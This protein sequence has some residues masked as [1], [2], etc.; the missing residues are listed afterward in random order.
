MSVVWHDLECGRYDADLPLW[1]ELASQF[2]APILDV[3]AGTGRV[4]LP[5][6]Q[7][8]HSVTALDNE[9]ELLAELAW[10]ADGL[11]L[12]TVNADAREFELARK[13]GLCVVPMQTVQLLG[14]SDGRLAFLDRARRH[15]LGGGRLAVAVADELDVFELR[16]GGLG[17]LPD[18]TELEG[19]VYSSSPTAVRV[20]GDGFELERRREVVSPEGRLSYEMNRIHLDRL[21]VDQLMSEGQAAGLKVA[22]AVEIKATPEHVGSVVVM[23][24]A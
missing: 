20:Q 18:V 6:A 24:D 9:P 13:F 5:L 1:Q 22:P 7:A 21:D 8:G 23:F 10:R 4:A 3:G 15:L 12:E 16:P 2:P 17:P 11:D 19:V 14:G